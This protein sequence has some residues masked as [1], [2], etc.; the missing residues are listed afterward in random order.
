VRLS[1][2][3]AVLLVVIGVLFAAVSRRVRADD[4]RP[5]PSA[6]IV[7]PASE[8]GTTLLVGGAVV[9]TVAI[10]FVFLMLSIAAGRFLASLQ[11]TDAL[12]I[13]LIGHQWWWEVRY[14]DRKA[15]V[16]R[17]APIGIVTANE[18]H[19]PVGQ[20]VHVRGSS[21]D[22]IH[23][24]WAPNL[25]GKRDLIPGHSTEIWI[26][27]DRD[28]VYPAQCAEY[29]GYQHALMRLVVVAESPGRFAAWL[30]AQRQPATTPVTSPEDRGREV[31]L[32]NPC[33][34]CH[35]IRGTPAQGRLAPDLT[36]LASRL[37]IAAGTLP[38]S[39]GHLANWIVNPQAVKPRSLMPASALPASDLQALVS[40]LGSLR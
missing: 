12:T 28:G 40:Y 4:R 30:E 17:E 32:S 33:A 25:H 1:V 16:D 38:N 21:D 6:R 37:T 18:I 34:G 19:V 29:C 2:S 11:A 24:F 8:R 35:T 3:A 7:P 23:S 14:H 20:P 9:A 27:A 26:Q 5:P 10:L 13:D 22:V 36:H 39:P 15:P 31:F